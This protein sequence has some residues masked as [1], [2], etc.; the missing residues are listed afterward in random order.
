M[1]FSERNKVTDI[2]VEIVSLSDERW[3]KSDRGYHMP[4]RR[5]GKRSTANQQP[6]KYRPNNHHRHHHPH[7]HHPHRHPPSMRILMP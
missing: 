6:T 2:V 7:R 5:G 4:K 3:C 1:T